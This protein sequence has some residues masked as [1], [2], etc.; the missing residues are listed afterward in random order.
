MTTGEQ[1]IDVPFIACA[2][3]VVQSHQIVYFAED[4][5]CGTRIRLPESPSWILVSY[6]TTPLAPAALFGR[7][8]TSLEN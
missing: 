8:L 4:Q 7:Q 3:T 5:V 2:A 6:L 1:G